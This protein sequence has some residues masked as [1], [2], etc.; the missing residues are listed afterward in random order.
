MDFS[1]YIS[2]CHIYIYNSNLTLA[3]NHS[4]S[5]LAG[6]VR[7]L[8]LK[9]SS[10]C[11]WQDQTSLDKGHIYSPTWFMVQIKLYG[12]TAS[13]ASYCHSVTV[14]EFASNMLPPGKLIDSSCQI[15]TCRKTDSNCKHLPRY[16][17]IWPLVLSL[18]TY[19]PVKIMYV[20]P[21]SLM[22]DTCS[23][24]CIFLDQSP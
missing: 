21:I 24:V 22:H 23:V 4:D 1:S 15:H 9:P 6:H 13:H 10:H 2:D 18:A 12:H 7:L 16:K 8:L 11:L 3:R 17:Q 5:G 14:A 19:F 20:S